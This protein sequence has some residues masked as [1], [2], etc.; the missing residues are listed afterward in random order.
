MRTIAIVALAAAGLTLAACSRGEQNN[1]QADANAAGAEL[2][3]ESAEA[4]NEIGSAASNLATDFQEGAKDAAAEVSSAADA[5]GSDPD[6]REAGAALG[7]AAKDG[8][9]ALGQVA[10]AAIDA[11][12]DRDN[13]DA[14]TAD[15]KN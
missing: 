14:N 15:P 13:A 6:V 2:K 3:A 9:R 8:G 1:A 7:D 10:G 11:A 12:R 4:A 5:I